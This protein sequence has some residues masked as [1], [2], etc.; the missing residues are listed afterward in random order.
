VKREYED[1]ATR[2]I[3]VD[4]ESGEVNGWRSQAL[5]LRVP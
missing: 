2:W 5:K 4:R 3:G 1:G